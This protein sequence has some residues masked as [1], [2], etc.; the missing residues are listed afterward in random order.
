MKPIEKE[1]KIEKEFHVSWY[2]IFYKFTFGLIELVSGLGIVLFGKRILA[3][4]TILISQ[5]LLE[6]PHDLFANL[7]TKIAPNIFTHNT[8][9]SL[10]LIIL[11]IAKIAG[12]IGLIYKQN[13]G[14][15]ILVGLTILMFPFQL[16]HLLLHPSIFDSMYITLGV[17]IALYLIEFKPKA[18]ISRIF[19]DKVRNH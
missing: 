18:W 6:D 15:D 10:Y 16:I 1:I 5:E 13:W 19:I 3:K 12:S 11:G 9:L 8:F 4:F 17:L 7:G 2:I 14:V